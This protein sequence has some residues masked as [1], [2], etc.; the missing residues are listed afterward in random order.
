MRGIA[1]RRLALWTL[2]CLLAAAPA[3]AAGPGRHLEITEVAVDFGTSTIAITGQDFDFGG[4]L[5]VSLG[6]IGDVTALCTADFTPPQTITCDF[7]IV[8]MPADG[9]YLLTVATGNGQSQNDEYDL[10]IGATGAQGP[11]G[12]PGPQGPQGDPGPQGPQGAQGDPGPQ[13]S[14]GDPGPEGPPGPAG[15]GSFYTV[16]AVAMAAGGGMVET[17]TAE[18]LCAPGD[19]VVGGGF[20][21]DVLEGGHSTPVDITSAPNGTDTGWVGLIQRIMPAGSTL[22]VWAR[23]A[24]LTP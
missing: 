13:G 12:E 3:I 18:A 2:A 9:D 22:T 20:T 1:S 23:C 24:D 4:G 14:Q 19:V 17:I 21:H 10:T 15:A 11:Q 7:S 5:T 8:G 6:E 16:S